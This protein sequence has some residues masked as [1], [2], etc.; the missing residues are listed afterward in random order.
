MFVRVK[1]SGTGTHAREYL[2]IVESRRAGGRVRQHVI[3]TLGRRDRLVADGTLDSL[4]QS[5]ARFSERLRIVE[6]VC[7]EGVEAVAARAR[8]RRFEFDVERVGFALA[9]QRLC[10]PG[11]DLQGAAWVRTVECPGF[12]AVELQHFYRTVGWLA[13][14]RAELETDLFWRDR[15]LFS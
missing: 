8:E 7:A 12:E 9:L 2:Q 3:A 11:S 5:L 4:L 15:E 13:Q 14:I 10:A 1:S 6:R